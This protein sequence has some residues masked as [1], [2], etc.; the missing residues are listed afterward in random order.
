MVLEIVLILVL[1]ALLILFYTCGIKK[2]IY[3]TRNFDNKYIPTIASIIIASAIGFCIGKLVGDLITN[4][5]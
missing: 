4:C 5:L 3:L 2:I 1:L